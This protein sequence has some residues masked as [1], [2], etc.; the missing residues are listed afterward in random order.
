MSLENYWIARNINNDIYDGMYRVVDDHTSD[1]E[2][3]IVTASGM[4]DNS[5]RF[6]QFPVLLTCTGCDAGAV[7][8]GE[9]APTCL[10]NCGRSL[11]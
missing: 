11:P 8:Y 2:V 6:Y 10:G 3:H 4:V 7:F 5:Q 1:D 9:S